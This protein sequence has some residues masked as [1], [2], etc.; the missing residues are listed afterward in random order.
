M[1]RIAIEEH[2]FTEEYLKYLRSRKDYPR[3][4]TLKIKDREMEWLQLAPG[5]SLPSV[6]HLQNGL[7]DVGEGR[8]KIMDE[9][10]CRYA[11]AFS[12]LFPEWR[13]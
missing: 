8:L 3:L 9:G 7:L 1:K 12:E 10:G 11:G 2:F 6:P 5:C 4:E 13:H